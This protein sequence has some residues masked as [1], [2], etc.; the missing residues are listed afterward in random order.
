MDYILE[1]NKVSK[2][3]EKSNFFLDQ[4]SFALPYGS[5]MGFVGETELE[6]PQQLTAY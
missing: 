5:I 4:I 3:Y 1:L 6:K 2:A